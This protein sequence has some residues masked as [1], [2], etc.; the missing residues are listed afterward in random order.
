[1]G[2]FVATPGVLW[3]LAAAY[4]ALD[5]PVEGLDC[6]GEAAEFIEK[7]G[8]R[9]HESDVALVRGYLLLATGD[10]IMAEESYRRALAIATQRCGRTSELRGAT[11]LA[12]LWRDEGKR[13]EAVILLAPIYNWFTQGFDTPVLKEAKALLDE[14]HA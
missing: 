8:E 6:L 7:T 3:G 11:V 4:G 2:A 5:R 13:T 1:M 12:R 10:R 9:T 14:L